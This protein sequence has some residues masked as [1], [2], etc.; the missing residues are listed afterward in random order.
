VNPSSGGKSSEPHSSIRIDARLDAATRQKV[1]DLATRFH[2]PRAAVICHIMHW[3]LSRE[4]PGPLTH[5][6]SPAP[7]RHLH[8]SVLSDLHARVEK[9]AA[10]AG[11]KAASWLRHMARQIAITD[12]SVSWQEVTPRERS[13]HSRTHTERFML[14]LDDPTREKLEDL[15]TQFNES[16]AEVIHQLI[17]Q[18]NP[19]DFPQSWRMRAAEHHGRGANCITRPIPAATLP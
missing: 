12:F 13:H 3:G 15:S 17:T 11:V 2:R 4:R 16:A 6:V 10:A 8:H 18:A 14:R 9:A 19:E 5:G 1:D 7:V